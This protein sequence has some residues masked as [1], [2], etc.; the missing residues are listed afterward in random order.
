MSVWALGL[1]H[2][3]APINVREQF[4]FAADQVKTL[5]ADFKYQFGAEAEAEVNGTG[6]TR[7]EVVLADRC[8]DKKID[9]ARQNAGPVEGHTAGLGRGVIKTSPLGPPAALGDTGYCLEQARSHADAFVRLGELL[10]DPRRLHNLW[11]FDLT[12]TP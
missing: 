3:T 7:F 9:L 4:A 1:N 12:Q 6:H 2:N 11:C 5:L 10:V 8:R